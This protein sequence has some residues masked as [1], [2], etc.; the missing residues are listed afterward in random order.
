MATNTSKSIPQRLR[1]SGPLLEQTVLHQ[2][3][4]AAGGL[5]ERLLDASR[6]GYKLTHEEQYLLALAARMYQT[7]QRNE[8]TAEYEL[9]VKKNGA[10]AA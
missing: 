10:T 2:A 5:I 1:R 3:K 9:R 6:L 4:Q 8:W 7:I